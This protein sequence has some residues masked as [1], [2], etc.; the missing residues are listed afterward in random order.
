M[1]FTTTT[2]LASLAVVAAAAKDTTTFAVLRFN[3]DGFLTEGP[4]DPIVNPGTTSTHYHSIMGGSNFG[5]TVEGDQLLDSNCTTAKIK[6]DHSNYW[7]PQ[8]F[9]QDPKNPKSFE[10]VS[11]MYMNVYYFFEE[12][13]SDVEAFP[14]GLKMMIG[15]AHTRSPPNATGLQL[16]PN[17]SAG[18]NP[19][20]WTCPRTSYT[21]PSYPVDSDG[22]KAGIVDPN[23]AG[24][25]AGFPSQKCDGLYSPLRQD[26]HFPSCYNPEAGLDAYKTNMAWPTFDGDKR[27]CPEGYIHVPHLFFEVYWST[28]DFNDRWDVD[29]V[30]QPFVL[31]NGD[32][33]GFSSHADFISGWDKDTLNTIIGSC[34]AGT[35]GMD[36]CPDIP[37]GLSEDNDCKISPAMGTMLKT[38][39]TLTAL[40]L[41]NPVTG[42]GK[43]GVTGGSVGE[44]SS[45]SE[46][47]SSASAATTTYP[48]SAAET[49]AASSTSVAAEHTETEVAASSP[50]EAA[51][52]ATEA[53]SS[54]TE[55]A[56]SATEAATYP[57]GG[58]FIQESA[59]S[60]TTAETAAA[61]VTDAPAAPAA[62]GDP[63]IKTVWDYVTV[64]S[65]TTVAPDASPVSQRRRVPRHSHGHMAR[66]LGGG[67]AGRR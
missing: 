44:S 24:A 36:T 64:T 30:N 21:P 52:S 45:G 50:T 10:K 4:M 8:L 43:G 38:S 57:T 16:D 13:S 29:G 61:A 19:V 25:G 48:T 56:S 58:A 55:A 62:G 11:M 67:F 42:W 35:L 37:G 18:I 3:G 63:N 31:S 66:H 41:D 2:T 60:A 5:P 39:A 14:V 12:S 47:G 51:S 40:P 9:F 32:A 46:S 54:A 34:N 28:P 27:E 17:N 22:T 15:D 33:T 53:A 59:S 20:Q 7:I 1:K 6:N 26:L 49:D 23:N 65:T